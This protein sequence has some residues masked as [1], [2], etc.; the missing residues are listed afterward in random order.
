MQDSHSLEDLKLYHSEA[1]QF[2]GSELMLLKDIISKI[3][4]ERL[5]KAIPLLI[6]C[7]QTGMAL[8][9]MST[10]ID[11]HTREVVMLSRSFMETI[12]NFCYVGVCDEKEFRAFIL[13]PI[14]KYYHNASIPKIEEHLDLD[15]IVESVK[16]F[17]AIRKEK[18]EELKKKPLVQEALAV[19]SET[20][21]NLNWSKKNLNQKIEILEKWGKFMDFLFT[22]N[23]IEYY[24]DASEALHGSLY[25]CTYGF[26]IFDPDF[27]STSKEE[28][29]KKLYK[30][31]TYVLLHLGMLIH[32]SFTLISYSNDIEELYNHSYNNR[33]QALNLLLYVMGRN[34]S[35][36][37]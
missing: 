33:T 10:K 13:H 29:E 1:I 28:L 25:G 27:N 7:G 11:C 14:Y 20:K 23:K 12:T 34:N 36:N 30:E 8:L 19:F 18:Q 3:V 2:F 26:G 9:Q 5:S 16:K 24:S 32:E 6:A 37:H 31:N 35:Y 21:K 4:D 17:D 15:K 22:L